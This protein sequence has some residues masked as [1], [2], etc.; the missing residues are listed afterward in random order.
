MTTSRRT[1]PFLFSWCLF[2]PPF[3]R[4][5]PNVPVHDRP[6]SADE[7]TKKR[8]VIGTCLALSDERTTCIVVSHGPTF[9]PLIAQALST[10]NHQERL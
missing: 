9:V 1:D 5:T 8:D 7:Y 4:I 6:K 3:G 2:Y 10:T